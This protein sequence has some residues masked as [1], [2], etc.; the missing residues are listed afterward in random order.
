L[1][2]TSTIFT[3]DLDTKGKESGDYVDQV[4][5]CKHLQ[6]WLE[7]TGILGSI[8]LVKEEK[9]LLCVAPDDLLD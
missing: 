5:N 8:M 4:E 7:L 9:P 1:Y 2:G 6:D 3:R